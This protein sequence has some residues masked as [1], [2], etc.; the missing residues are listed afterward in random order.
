MNSK[1]KVTANEQGLV[2]VPST[3]NPD[4]GH[5]RVTQDVTTIDENTGF[6]R[7]KSISALMPGK[8]EDLQ[9]FGWK[10]NQE[11]SGKIVIKESLEPFNPNDPERDFKYAGDTG[12]IC[13]LNGN[14]I[15]RKNF[16][17]LN[18]NAEDVKVQHDNTAEII[19]ARKSSLKEVAGTGFDI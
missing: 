10:N 1:V 19:A 9:A 13:M 4:Y 17:T 12:V 18:E 5:I 3:N 14:P 6:V 15:Y 8:V 7:R 2:V 11:V 16:Y